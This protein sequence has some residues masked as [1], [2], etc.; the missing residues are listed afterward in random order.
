M[1]QQ[2]Q[3]NGGNAGLRSG[4]SAA[5][6]GVNVGASGGVG[7]SGRGRVAIAGPAA[8]SRRR[9]CSARSRRCWPTPAPGRFASESNR[10]AARGA[11]RARRGNLGDRAGCDG[12]CAA[13]H[14]QAR[15]CFPLRR[16]G[17]R[18]LPLQTSRLPG[19][20]A[21]AEQS[22][23]VAADLLDTENDQSTRSMVAVTWTSI[24]RGTCTHL[25]RR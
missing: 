3:S 18:A 5:G 22:L 4:P 11:K 14:P 8:N 1:Q 25:P 21:S 23:R 20:A 6:V 2:M 24:P 10:R 17:R 9:A 16:S 13:R 15:S 12:W 19:P 7:S